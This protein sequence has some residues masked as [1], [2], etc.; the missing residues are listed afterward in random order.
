MTEREREREREREIPKLRKSYGERSLKEKTAEDGRI[1][2]DKDKEK[3]Y[4][5]KEA[6]G[7]PDRQTE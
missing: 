4:P 7:V 6:N 2:K 3:A 1:Q 5:S